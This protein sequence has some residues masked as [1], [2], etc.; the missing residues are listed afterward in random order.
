MVV[1]FYPTF[2]LNHVLHAPK[3]IK[4]LISVQKF[5]TDNMVSISF[6]PYRF[7]VNDLQ[8]G[9]K[10]MRC[11]SS[12]DLY[13]LFPTSQ[14]NLSGTHSNFSALSTDL[15][16]NRLGHPGDVVLRSLRNQKFIECNNKA[17]NS[18]CSS[19]PLGKHMKLPFY[20]SMSHTIFPFDIIHSDLWTSPILSSSGHGYCLLFLDDYSKFLWT[21]PITKKSQV[22][23]I[24]QSFHKIIHTQFERNIKTFQCDNGTEYV[25]GTLKNFFKSQGMLYRLSCPHASPQ[26]GKAELHIKSINNIIRTLLAHASLPHSFWHHA[27]AMATY[28]LNILPTKVLGYRSATQI[29]YQRTP[30]YSALRV[31]SYLCFPLFPSTTIHKLQERSTPCVYLGPA[32][33]HR[34]SKCYNLSNGKII[35]CRHVKFIENEFPFSKYHKPKFDDYDL[36][37][38]NPLVHLPHLHTNQPTNVTAQSTCSPGQQQHPTPSG[39]LPFSSP[40]SSQTVTPQFVGSQQTPQHTPILLPPTIDSPDL[41]SPRRE[42]HLSPRE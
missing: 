22:K 7:S 4:N 42:E 41:T 14:A 1:L 25:N 38:S 35:I 37:D 16:H 5:T 36:L 8:T 9:A 24:F 20:G 23:H 30:I 27:L 10:L 18:F 19:C 33:N 21:Y 6:D 11:D 29:L 39:P 3:L 2:T 26:N 28:L 13:P 32:P 12:G 31:F 17:C 15:W 34:G 40:A